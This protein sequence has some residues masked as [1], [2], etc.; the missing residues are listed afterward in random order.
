M[1]CLVIGKECESPRCLVVK[2][3]DKW[4]TERERPLKKKNTSETPQN[5]IFSSL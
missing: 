2:I 4:D 5:T 1:G 3:L